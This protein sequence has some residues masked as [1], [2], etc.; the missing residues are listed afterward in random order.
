MILQFSNVPSQSNV[1]FNFT[2]STTRS[3][4]GSFNHSFHY[5]PTNCGTHESMA[6]K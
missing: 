1:L 2:I 3:Q 5:T 4:D 6:L